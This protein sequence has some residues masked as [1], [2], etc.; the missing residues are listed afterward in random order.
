VYPLRLTT[1]AHAPRSQ[2]SLHENRDNWKKVRADATWES[3][4]KKTLLATRA[5]RAFSRGHRA[6]A[7]PEPVAAGSQPSPPPDA[8]AAAPE[9]HSSG[10]PREAAVP[11]DLARAGTT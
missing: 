4:K 1:C 10:T 3:A 2:A 6:G 11:P 9:A 7:S 8:T 5:S